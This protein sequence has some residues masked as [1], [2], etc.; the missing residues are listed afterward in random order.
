VVLLFDHHLLIADTLMITPSG[1]ANWDTNALGEPRKRPPGVNTFAFMY[2][3]PNMIPLSPDEIIN[4]WE[5]LKGY[6][7]KR[8]HGAF[9][10][11]DVRDDN[12]KTRVLK[13][14]QIQIKHM[15]YRDHPFLH[16]LW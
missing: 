6:N 5:I 7:F 13:S 11:Y 10:H 1:L 9:T 15:G 12:V 16:S 14:M 4:M 8:C 2:S 3:I